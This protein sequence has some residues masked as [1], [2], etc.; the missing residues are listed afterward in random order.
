MPKKPDTT[1][2]AVSFEEA[3]QEL[4]QLVARMEAGELPLEAS[5]AAY[6]RGSELVK[7]CTAQLEKVERQVKILESDMLKPF[8]LDGAEDA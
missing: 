3:M 1:Q 8:E 4:E 6:Q 5:V 2:P 7:Q